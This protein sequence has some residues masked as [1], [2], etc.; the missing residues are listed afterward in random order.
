MLKTVSSINNAIGAL[1]YK[2]TWDASTNTPTL[3]S[4]VGTKGDYY[5]VS[6]AGSTSLDGLSNWGIGDW[7]AFN[8][9]AWQRV[10]GGADL[11][12]VNLSVSGTSTLGGD[13]SIEVGAGN[14]ELLIKTAGAGNNPYIQ[15]QADTNVFDMMGVFSSDP[16]YWRVG[17]G[18]SGTA[19]VEVL[20]VFSGGDVQ[21][22]NGNLIVENGKGIDFSATAGTGT[23]ELLDDY[24]EGVWTPALTGAGGSSGI[25]YAARSGSY[26]KIGRQVTCKGSISLSAKTSITGAVIISQ[27]PFVTENVDSVT[28]IT[29][30]YFANLG[31]NTFTQLSGYMQQS[32]ANCIIGGKP[33]SGTSFLN[34]SDAEITATTRID[35]IT[36]YLV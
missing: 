31:A 30:A 29:W 35:F 19:S 28:P 16:D 17:Y 3:A 27:F 4:G 8:G 1:N 10:E 25:T 6:V 26:V 5:V 23:S 12:G 9:S 36:T 14:P 11:N 7:A 20:K 24:E 34:F 32:Q 2:G 33:T 13:V 22:N 15:L 18:T 21:I